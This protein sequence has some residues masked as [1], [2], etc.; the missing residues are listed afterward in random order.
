MK[1]TLTLLIKLRGKFRL[2]FGFC[3][4]CNSDTPKLYDCKIC[5]WGK[6]PK[7][8]WWFNFKRSLT[9]LLI[10]SMFI[11]GCSNETI[12]KDVTIVNQPVTIG[13]WEL[14]IIPYDECEYVTFGS[15][16]CRVFTHKGNCKN[17]IHIYNS[18]TI[19]F[20]K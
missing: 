4:Q 8:L 17:K 20:K 2:F 3:P 7:E 15:G 5:C 12:N 10:A 11:I 16:D 18:D 13:G 19:T 9:T 1:R 14:E 6:Q